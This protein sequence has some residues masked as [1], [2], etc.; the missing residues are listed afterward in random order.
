M[1]ARVAEA[2]GDALMLQGDY[3]AAADQL[4]RA[5]G[6]THDSVTR[7]VLNGKLGDVAFKQG[8]QVNA[9]RSLEGALRAL[10]RWVPRRRVSMLAAAL[11]ESVVQCLH[12]VAPRFFVAR[13]TL[14]DTEREFVAIRM[15]SRLAHVYWFS[16][17]KVPC[18]WAHLREMNLAERYPPTP[19]L[20]Q[21]YSDHAPV[22]TVLSWYGRG[23]AYARRSLDIRREAGDVWGQGQSLSFV[24]TVLYASSRYRECIDACRE[25]IRLLERTGGRWEQNTATWHQA[26]AH[27]R[28]G[29]LDVALDMS[30]DLYYAATAIG[31]A[32][33]AGI[34]LSGWARAGIG[35]VPDAFVA[36]EIGRDLGDAHTATEVH[37]ADGVRL[38]Y[39]GDLEGA[40]E[41]F[42]EALGIISAAGLRAE[43]FAPPRPWLATALRMQAE[44]VDPGE[45]RT[46]ARLLRRAD[47]AARRAHR[48]AR[49]YPNNLPHALRERSIVAGLRGHHRRASVRFARSL[50]ISQEQEAAY[51]S[52]LTRVALAR[53][54]L[55]EGRVDARTELSEAEVERVRLEPQA[56]DAPDRATYSLADR[57]EVLLDVG[58]R[59][60][61][62]V[63]PAAVYQEVHRA[64]MQILRGDHCNVV[65]LDDEGA[66]S[67][68]MDSGSVVPD[69][70]LTLM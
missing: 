12:S 38:L 15:Y 54:A 69:V 35:R 8:D 18:L 6:L 3:L 42:S 44:G 56:P 16:A 19:E 70:S 53:F 34:A 31:D 48:L 30:R 46:R 57:F 40:V 49:A 10:G 33:A 61:A 14:E 67:V 60:G 68:V 41:R 55:A 5:L 62:A 7:A 58:R 36:I 29:E 13:R 47:R 50:R 63:S 26:F 59:I 25:S 17:G 64:A 37:L 4:Q 1:S 28:L 21:A 9:A 22:M 65:R 39:A 52:A 2:L 66:V 51:E 20:A 32:T 45:S 23:L 11:F 27:Y 43:Y 24:A